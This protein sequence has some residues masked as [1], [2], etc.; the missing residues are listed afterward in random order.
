MKQL[1]LTIAAGG[2]C[3][4]LGA[5]QST[6]QPSQNIT[7]RTEN[8]AGAVALHTSAGINVSFLPTT[9]TATATVSVTAP[10]NYMEYVMVEHSGSTV[11]LS[12]NTKGRHLDTDVIN[13]TV[14][15]SSLTTLDASSGS[16]I[17]ILGR[18]EAEPHA[19]V[20]LSASSGADIEVDGFLH[21]TGELTLIAS[22]GADIDIKGAYATSITI[23]ASSGADIEVD[24]LEAV[25][26][27][28]NA[29]SGAD[30]KLSGRATTLNAN[31]SSGGDINA[32][33]LH[34]GIT[35]A[36]SVDQSSQ[37]TVNTDTLKETAVDATGTVVAE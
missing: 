6:L 19:S 9:D 4:A 8:I 33:N 20:T 12:L 25:N 11:S 10:D 26:V 16:D 1:I 13:V 21:S 36:G 5:C 14:T 28:A 31:G 3:L 30:I 18:W 23:D 17:K 35:V 34:T 24:N 15:S 2:M 29:S 22:S 32:R 37:I 7:T 27:N